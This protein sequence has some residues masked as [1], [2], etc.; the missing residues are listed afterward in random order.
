MSAYD[1][2]WLIVS[3]DTSLGEALRRM[4]VTGRGIL[5]VVDAETGVRTKLFGEPGQA[6]PEALEGGAGAAQAEGEEVER[7]AEGQHH[8][9]HRVREQGAG[10]GEGGADEVAHLARRCG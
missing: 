2:Q 3:P 5:L 4:D 7:G 10:G 9:G 6:E 8:Q 1:F